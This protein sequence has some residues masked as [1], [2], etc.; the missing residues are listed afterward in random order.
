MIISATLKYIWSFIRFI[1]VFLY[2]FGVVAVLTI[3]AILTGIKLLYLISRDV[4]KGG[5][6]V[7]NKTRIVVSETIINPVLEKYI[8]GSEKADEGVDEYTKV[9]FKNRGEAVRHAWESLK[10][11]KIENTWNNLKL[12]LG[13]KERVA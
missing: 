11:G 2:K 1:G 5:Y 4:I 10:G 9:S 12:K 8:E 13:I 3:I 7:S 6:Y